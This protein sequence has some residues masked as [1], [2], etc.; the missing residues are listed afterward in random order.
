MCGIIGYIGNTSPIDILLNGL[1]H[2]EYRGYDSAGIAL[3]NLNRL[4]VIK[5]AGKLANLQ[6]EITQSSLLSAPNRGIGHIRWATH[7]K[8]NTV[9]AHPHTSLNGNLA[10]VHNGIIENYKAL[11]AELIAQGYV[12][13]S[14]TDTEVIAHLIGFY[15]Q[16][17]SNLHQAT[18]QAC[19]R[20]QGAYA[21]GIIS[22]A[23]PHK[24]I[25][26]R[27]HA[28]LILGQSN[29]GHYIASDI[30]ALIGQADSTLSLED[31]ELAELSENNITIFAADNTICHKTFTPLTMSADSI[32]K[33]GY[34]HY[35]LKEI[36]EQGNITRQLLHKRLPSA[37]AEVNLPDINISAAHLHE[38]RQIEII[39]CGTSL[40]AAEVGKYLIEELTGISTQVMAAS[41]YLCRRSLS[42]EHTLC[43]GVSQ[44]GET[45]DTISAIRKAKEHHAH[46]LI[47]TNRPDSSITRYADSLLPLEA[48]IE[49]SVAATK[50]YTA[51]LVAFYLLSLYLAEHLHSIDKAQLSAL[52]QELLQIP[53]QIEEILQNDQ[54]IKACAQQFNHSRNFIY[55]S[56][57][58]NVATAQE[59][60]LKLKEISY[61]NAGAYPAGELKHGPIALL[62]ETLPVVSILIPG[63][64]GYAKLLS[65]N[66]EAKARKAP[67]IAITSSQDKELN[68]LFNHIITVPKVSELLSPLTTNIPLQ[69]LAYYIADS[70]GRDVDQPRNLAKSV[71]V[72]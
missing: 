60:A 9:N 48:G 11:K 50:S 59:G 37:E 46:I 53:T 55:M 4:M 45:A 72:E 69:L 14:E 1:K 12:F 30:P 51:Q 25:A 47:L 38:I 52:K 18:R 32:D 5:A 41:E 23:E 7:G 10:I 67:L 21:L 22:Q 42:S 6:H 29:S 27:H 62:D 65:N 20:L 66:E 56:R 49:V 31:D 19:S 54:E 24:L 16:Q 44:S 40:H 35:M 64:S 71:T 33:L 34:R 68:K 36:H 26:V 17:G 63:G 15:L 2:L 61:I 43:I 8:G 13:Q 57:G 39:A 58:I 70:L 28:P 3:G